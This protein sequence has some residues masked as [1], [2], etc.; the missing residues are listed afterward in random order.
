MNKKDKKDI[1]I[2]VIIELDLYERNYVTVNNLEYI[3]YTSNYVNGFIGERPVYGIHNYI[4]HC[5]TYVQ[6]LLIIYD[7]IQDKIVLK[8]K[9]RFSRK[10]H[11]YHIIKTLEYVSYLKEFISSNFK[12]KEV[13]LE[14]LETNFLLIQ[15]ESPEDIKRISKYDINCIKAKIF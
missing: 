7:R 13:L 1:K 3:S 14:R 4:Y 6:K 8:I 9:T 15:N 10:D 11:I 5:K 2:Q 12:F